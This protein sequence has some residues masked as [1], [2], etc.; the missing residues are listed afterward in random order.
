LT[1]NLVDDKLTDNSFE[2]YQDFGIS[3]ES[4][5]NIERMMDGN[6]D[7]YDGQ[8]YNGGNT[9]STDMGYDYIADMRGFDGVK[10][11][12]YETPVVHAKKKD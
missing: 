5:K 8:M 3:D 1:K 10:P 9:S 4:L 7:P 2:H 11:E 12:L 6:Q